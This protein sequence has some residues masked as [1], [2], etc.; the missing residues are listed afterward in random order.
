[1]EPIIVECILESMTWLTNVMH[2]LR[3]KCIDGITVNKEHC[4]AMVKNSIGIVTALNP[5]IGYKNS[6]KIAKE[7]LKTGGSIYDIVL[8]QG[9]LTKEEIDKILDPENMLA[10]HKVPQL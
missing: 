6:T 4:E 8:E 9:I 7:A 2:T 5:Y 1:M 3:S 10:A